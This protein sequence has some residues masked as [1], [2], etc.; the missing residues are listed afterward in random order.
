[1]TKKKRLHGLAALPPERRREI[2]A[3]GGRKA[4]QLGVASRWTPE[5]ARA[6]GARGGQKT[7]ASRTREEFQ[8][9]G[10]EGGLAKSR[11]M[12]ARRAAEEGHD[13]RRS[14]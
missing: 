7:A 3:M 11:N 10:R 5:Q 13:D 4:Q 14:D 12:Q 2:A 8:A 9:L 6:M 1:M